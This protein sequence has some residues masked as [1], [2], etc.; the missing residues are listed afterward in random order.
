[1]TLLQD[2]QNLDFS[3][4]VDA[5]AAITVSLDSPDL[6][7][8]LSGGAAQTALAGL[9]TSIQALSDTASEPAALIVPLVDAVG[10]L[11]GPLSTDGLP[12][13]DYLA[14]V[15]EG[16]SII[17]GLF[18]GID[19]PVSFGSASG[20][21]IGGVLETAGSIMDDYVQV[22]LGDV[23]RFRNLI[24]TIEGGISTDP[25][26]LADLAID[27]LLPFPKANLAE[28]RDGV[29]S[30]LDIAGD[31][32]LPTGRISGLV[33][34]LEAVATAAATG[35]PEILEQALLYLDQVR[36]NTLSVLR[37]DLLAIST[38]IGDLR[39]DLALEPVVA[40]SS[41]LHTSGEDMI[42]LLETWRAQIALARQQ[43]ESLEPEQIIASLTYILDIIEMGARAQFIDRLDEMTRQLEEWVRDLFRHL[44]LRDLRAELSQFIHD[45]AQAI[46]DA[47]L[48]R[49]AREVRQMLDD[50]Q[51]FVE[52]ADLGAEVQAALAD[53]KAAI[54]GILGG[55]TSA[56]TTIGD[57]INALAG[58]AEAI[59]QRAADAL[60]G[61][62]TTM[63]EI[64]AA[65]E[66]LGVEQA[67]QQ[68][69][70]TLRELRET[71]EALL[72]IAPLPDSLRPMIEQLIDTLE[73]IDFDVVFDPVR[74]AVAELEIPDDV[75]T[76]ITEALEATQDA[77]DNLI[78]AE[79]IASIETEITEALD[80]I[81]SFD[82]TALLDEVTG[83]LD[84]AADFIE[85]LDPRPAVA[86]IRGPYQA[87][88]DAVDAVHPGVLLAPVIEAYDDL[89]RSVPV[90]SPETAVRRTADALGAADEAVGQTVSQPIRQ[91][92]S[93]EA[94][95]SGDAETETELPESLLAN[96]RPGDIIRLLGYLPDKLREALAELDE[97][98][99][100][101]ALRAIDA[102][103]GGLAQDLRNLQSALWAIEARI[104]NGM[105]EMLRP[106]GAVQLRAQL[107][108]Q[109]NFSIGTHGGMAPAMA[110]VSLA[111]PAPM[112]TALAD[113]TRLARDR[114]RG[115]VRSAGGQTG[116]AL[117]RAAAA[118]ES[119]YLA[120][121][122]GD[123]D[124][125]LAAL[126]PEP[127]AA[128]LDALAA[129][130]IAKL[131][132]VMP[133][134]T[135]ELQNIV[136]RLQDLI[137]EFSPGTWGQ[138]LLVV[139]DVLREELNVL[140]PRRLAAELGEIH[141][142]VRETIAAYDP[143]VFAEEIYEVVVAVAAS[144]RSLN[145]ADLLGD[146]SF[147]DDTLDQITAALPS[148]ALE[149]VG[150]SL[151]EVGAQL[152][153]L[154]PAGLI[155]ALNQLGPRVIDALEAAVEAIRREIVA[156]LEALRYASGSVSVT[157]TVEVG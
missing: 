34:A 6:Q 20:F 114:A 39:V 46:R 82:P 116:A 48:D 131:V 119:C 14:A 70:D 8:V 134:I 117:E 110:T 26:A 10:E 25:Q 111:G 115:A 145:P 148:A 49:Y 155:E 50:I 63:N 55:V 76:G 5:R 154:D 99:A 105:E 62:Q 18:Q 21:S 66:S 149:G 45:I 40:A 71:A 24:D 35:D 87:I 106:L 11:A 56:L 79:L 19:D 43:I 146:L 9:G 126:D 127:I 97:G 101:D 15:T 157:A 130:A 85:G 139:V 22:G 23:T 3:D 47:D 68:V 122:G 104:N 156:L 58:E 147:L 140:D 128:E 29:K 107:A 138:K 27:I 74:A 78:P 57:R 32:T 61:F 37:D 150:T 113:T 84:E 80:V 92:A 102:L 96:I 121:L 120:R 144:L 2:L 129:A 13:A 86:E 136:Q 141:T 51:A 100:G 103:C 28:M 132:D 133:E 52:S 135:E 109:A 12:L 142:A 123:L 125:F 137:H 90:P 53:A 64:T 36:Q 38:Q 93:D 91:L 81:R 69:T 1:M 108:I 83:Y 153:E 152:A 41:V 16:A 143:A 118:L 73:G 95:S 112:R 124:A 31:I 7:A 33:D 65:V 75:S 42:K 44:P 4:I 151:A 77:L 98:I 60:A 30:I 59:L 54:D 88:L 17:T 67:Q 94:S 89:M 72:T